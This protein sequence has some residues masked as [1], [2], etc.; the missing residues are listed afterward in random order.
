MGFLSDINFI[1]NIAILFFLLVTAI[2]VIMSRNL[3]TAVIL[4]SIFS[5][6]MSAQYL[7][8]G[9]PDVAITEAAVGAG[10][11]TI[12]LLLA[13]FMASEKEK[14]TTNKKLLPFILVATVTAMLI[15]ASGHLPHFGSSNSPAQTH[16]AAY[17]IANSETDT[18]M[19]NA[20]T[21]IL[22]SYRGYDTFGEIL[23]IF[24][25]G[26]AVLMLLGRKRVMGNR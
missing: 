20:V 21:S 7:V 6:L 25:A 17:Y 23:V 16:V 26:I 11:S 22:A 2:S 5:M 15:Y 14:K 3:I 24:T 4:L 13:L 18:G 1:A 9:A 19:K 12:L 10:I 8:L